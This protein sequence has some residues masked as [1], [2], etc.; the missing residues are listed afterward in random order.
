MKNS[1]LAGWINNS[2]D[3]ELE[4]LWGA[5]ANLCYFSVEVIVVIKVWCQS[6]KNLSGRDIYKSLVK[7]ING[8]IFTKYMH[9]VYG[10][11]HSHTQKKTEKMDVHK[12][13]TITATLPSDNTN[14]NHWLAKNL[15]R[16]HQ[17][18]ANGNVLYIAIDLFAKIDNEI[19]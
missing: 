4:L 16:L 3:Y 7:N 15:V 12:N 17:V 18:H 5:I 2:W 11:G 13:I 10:W 6:F 14:H 19:K 8:L 1:H 9:S